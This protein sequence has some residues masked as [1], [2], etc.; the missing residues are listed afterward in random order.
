MGFLGSVSGKELTCQCK[1]YERDWFDPWVEKIPWRKARQ[2][3]PVFLP[4]ESLGQRSLAGYSPWG[5]KESDTT[6]VTQH[7]HTYTHTHTFF[8]IIVYSRRL[9]FPVLYRR[10]LLFIHA[11]CNSFASTNPIESQSVRPLL[12]SP[13][14]TTGLLSLSLSLLCRQVHLCCILGTTYKLYHTVFVVLSDFT[15]CENLQLHPC[16]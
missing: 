1:R 8:S 10:T 6:E 5:H 7:T 9:Q 2:H 13:L 14:I 4:E 3:T 12:S 15:S 16:D 11:K